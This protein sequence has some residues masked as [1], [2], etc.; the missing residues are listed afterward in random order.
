MKK[1]LIN[2]IRQHYPNHTADIEDV[3]LIEDENFPNA[4]MLKGNGDIRVIYQIEDDK[5]VMYKRSD[6]QLTESDTAKWKSIIR[7]YKLLKLGV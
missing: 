3:I 6:T 1:E 2:L 5:L 7:E 4:I